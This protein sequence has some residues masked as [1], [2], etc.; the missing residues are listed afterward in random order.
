MTTL[1][2]ART[3]YPI[4]VP[5]APARPAPYLEPR[6][7]RWLAGLRAVL[8]LAVFVPIVTLAAGRGD[9]E[10]ASWG[11]L[12]LA[13]PIVT[14]AVGL[15][16][17]TR[18]STR[19]VAP[20]LAAD[21]GMVLVLVWVTGG[22][23]TLF[24]PVLLLP[25][26]AATALCGRDAGLRVAVALVLGS[27]AMVALQ[28]GD[29]TA[30]AWLGGPPAPWLP[31]LRMA[32]ATFGIQALGVVSV[33][34]LVGHLS[35]SLDRTSA[36]LERAHLDLADLTTLS[37]RVLDSMVGGVVAADAAGRV[38]LFNRTAAAITGLSSEGVLGRPLVDVLQLP[39]GWQVG[40]SQ[41]MPA[42]FEF[43]FD[44]ERGESL[45]L[46][47]TVAPLVNDAGQ[48]AGE[49]VTFQDLTL[50]K[51]REREQQRQARLAAVGEMAAG[52]A[53][54]IRNPL[55]SISGSIQLLQRELS[56]RDDQAVLLDIVL[57]ESQRL[58]QTIKDF[59]TYAG[60]QRVSR[61]TIDVRP[62]ARETVELL[63]RG[64]TV[65]SRHQVVADVPELPVHHHVD[66]A[67]MRQVLWNLA[68]NALKA[69]PDGGRVT[70][71]V[72]H[73]A[74][75][76][77]REPTLVLAVEDEGVGME[78]EAVERM[79]QP[80]QGGFRQGTGLGLSIVHRIVTDHGGAVHVTSQPGCGTRVEVRIPWADPI[81]G[82]ADR[83]DARTTLAAAG[84]AA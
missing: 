77:R 42:R 62:L 24:A 48:V 11:M 18:A 43:S 39:A 46:G 34:L 17:A 72:T 78:P 33:A 23:T 60:P 21:V 4:G 12:L 50:I 16:T 61:A 80:F 74:E 63:M 58:N 53:H 57:R 22:I 6:G 3:W 35:A 51:Q 30:P 47:A 52:I 69:M 40:L 25:V 49:L 31:P 10:R 70:L 66:E 68:T 28:Y 65:G 82:R 32:L 37:Q 59:L 2:I 45:E 76:G 5:P 14:S 20:Q 73:E 56:L 26:L 36:D 75:S 8:A 9:M 38:V 67:Q 54:E 7:V 29:T 55:A 83:Q 71:H 79:F 1:P 64:G 15:A 44:R 41:G 19:I 84:G 81:D 27:G 13:I